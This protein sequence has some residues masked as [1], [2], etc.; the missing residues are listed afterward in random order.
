MEMT[1]SKK[2]CL[3]SRNISYLVIYLNTLPETM[4][5]LDQVK[6][7]QELADLYA[8][9]GI[10][11]KDSLHRDGMAA[12]ILLYLNGIYQVNTEAY[13]KAGEMWKE[14]HPHHRWGGD[15]PKPDGNHFEMMI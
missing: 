6:R 15:F 11:I 12:D 13:R 7:P 9:R 3:F 5:A 8:E 4:A 14:M 10:G 2:R 1:L